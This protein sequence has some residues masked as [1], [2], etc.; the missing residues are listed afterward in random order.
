MTNMQKNRILFTKYLHMS[1][2]MCIFAVDIVG[3][4]QSITC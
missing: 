2:K 4:K 3:N 1:E